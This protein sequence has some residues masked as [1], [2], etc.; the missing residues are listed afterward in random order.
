M[1]QLHFA[2]ELCHVVYESLLHTKKRAKDC[3]S[4]QSESNT[5]PEVVIVT[6]FNKQWHWHQGL[7]R[8]IT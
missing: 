4:G 6:R 1:Q 3:S 2:S 7:G 8:K 5:S